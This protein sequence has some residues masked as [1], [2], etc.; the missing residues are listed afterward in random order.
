MLDEQHPDREQ[1][2]VQVDEVHRPGEAGDPVGDPQLSARDPL[3]FQLHD[4][5]MLL[6]RALRPGLPVFQLRA[7]IGIGHGSS[8]RCAWPPARLPGA[9]YP[10]GGSVLCRDQPVTTSLS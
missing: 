6:A 7:L 9:G 1:R 2:D 8:F 5:R 3:R 4:S 10:G